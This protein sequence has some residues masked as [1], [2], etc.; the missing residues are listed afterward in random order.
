M[1]DNIIY[2]PLQQAPCTNGLQHSKKAIRCQQASI[3][4]FT[5]IMEAI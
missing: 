4:S 5:R 3:F 2:L 1:L